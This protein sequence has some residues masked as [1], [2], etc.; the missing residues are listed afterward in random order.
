[1]KTNEPSHSTSELEDLLKARKKYYY[2]AIKNNV[3]FDKLKA[4]Q[5]GISELKIILLKRKEGRVEIKGHWFIAFY[6]AI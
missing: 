6:N 5:E 4:I 2:E 1:M 3:K